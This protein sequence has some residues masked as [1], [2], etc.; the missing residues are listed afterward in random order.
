VSLY[1]D[2]SCLLKVLFPEPETA[3]VLRLVA[4]EDEV[5]VSNLARLEACV[6]I[7]ARTAGGGLTRA[8]ARALIARLATLLGQAPYELV[9]VP[10]GII[11][12][13]DAQ[14]RS[15]S[16][17]AYCPTLDRLHLAVMQDLDIRRVL[18][19]DDAQARAARALGFTVLVPR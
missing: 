16:K 18:T 1:L 11:E 3:Q 9:R 12:R 15:L 14:V 6:Q 4:T 13:A 19:N 17:D 10:A 8:A 5:V 7:H 2:T